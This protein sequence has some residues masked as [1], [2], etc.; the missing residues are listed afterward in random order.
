MIRFALILAVFVMA[1]CA[2]S[3]RTANQQYF[4][5]DQGRYIYPDYLRPAPLP[6]IPPVD[7]CRS[8]LYQGLVGQHEGAIYIPGLPGAKRV[9]KPG[10]NEGFD[11]AAEE[12]FGAPEVFLEVRDYLPDQTLYVPS[13]RTPGDLLQLNDYRT[14][15]LT[16]ELDQQGYVQEVRC[17]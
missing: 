12:T 4:P 1:S 14:D 2:Q 17:G 5:P 8:Q 9:I 16:V 13:I 6:Q 11:Y 15:R 7:A 3:P 10:F